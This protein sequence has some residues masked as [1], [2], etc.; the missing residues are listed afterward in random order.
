MTH[1]YE[2]LAE[3]CEYP[4]P[5][6][7]AA[8]ERCRAAIGPRDAAAAQLL[9]DFAADVAALDA[10]ELEELYAQTFDMNP[11]R[12]LDLGYQIFGETYK[13]G[14]FLVKMKD[15]VASHGVS[16]GVELHDHLPVV[17]RL[18]PRLA[19]GEHA[20]ELAGE[21]VLPAIEKVLRTFGADE[22]GYRRVLEAVKRVLM[23]DYGIATV[24]PAYIDPTA[25]E[26][27]VSSGGKRLPV[28]PGFNPPSERSLS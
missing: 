17:L 21:V 12:C 6:L 10:S 22:G 26:R 27:A 11:E 28:F 18:M 5:G 20:D 9:A 19:D 16:P 25:G 4:A 7:I 15:A 14:A 3:L 24:E 8:A 23:S 13:R 1:P 2:M